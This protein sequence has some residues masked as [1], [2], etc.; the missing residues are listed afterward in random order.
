MS[1]TEGGNSLTNI[2][3]PI[4]NAPTPTHHVNKTAPNPRGHTIPQASSPPPSPNGPTSHPKGEAKL[5]TVK[6]VQKLKAALPWGIQKSMCK[7]KKPSPLGEGGRREP[8]GRGELAYKHRLPH[9]Q[10]TYPNSPR[11]QNSTKSEGP[12]TPASELP[13][14][15]P[16]GPTSHP[17]GEAKLLTAK[18]VQTFNPIIIHDTIIKRSEQS[19]IKK[20]IR[21]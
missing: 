6:P 19:W 5:L 2:D 15:S 18:P 13:P 9:N 7:T 12:Y 20:E 8:D 3:C 17:K 16:N 10:R 1:L 11:K 21:H 14:P 4:T